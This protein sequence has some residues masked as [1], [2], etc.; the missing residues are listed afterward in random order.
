MT[1]KDTAKR[2]DDEAYLIICKDIPGQHIGGR[3]C[4][5]CPLVISANKSI[6]EINEASIKDSRLQ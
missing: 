6:E 5:C 3:D 1:P 4:F 2:E